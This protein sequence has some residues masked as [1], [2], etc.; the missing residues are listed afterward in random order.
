M[1]LPQSDWLG[2][3]EKDEKVDFTENT[4]KIL[5]ELKEQ[6]IDLWKDEKSIGI[7]KEKVEELK[8]NISRYSSECDT[9]MRLKLNEMQNLVHDLNA[10]LEVAKA[11]VSQNRNLLGS[12][13]RNSRING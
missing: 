5:L 7:A 9:K 2:L 6:G 4:K 1:K 12:I 8:I 3:K 13:N 11:I 10:I